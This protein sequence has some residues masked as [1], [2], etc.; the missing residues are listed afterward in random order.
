[1]CSR[2]LAVIV[3]VATPW[4]AAAIPSAAQ[5]S[6]WGANYFPDVTLTT[7]DG[8]SVHFYGDLL[9]G[10][11]VAI[12][13]IYTTCKY[14]CPLETARLAQ[15][16]KLLGDRMGR[17]V[18]FYSITIDPEHD[19]PA[20]LKEY[21]ETFHAGPG[22]L[23]LTGSQEDIELISKKVGLYSSP[24]PSDP[25]GHIPSL[26]V[27]NE[28]TG[29]WMRNSGVDNPKFLAR[30]IG[31]WLNSWQGPKRELKSYA[32]AM[33]L[34]LDPGEYTFN[35]HCA[36]CH[37]FGQGDHIGPDLLGIT[38]TRDRAWLARFILAPDRMFADGDPI[39]RELFEKYKNVRMPNLALSP[40]A[41]AGVVEYLVK[42]DDRTASVTA[43]AARPRPIAAAAI[44][45][46]YLRIQEALSAD[47][48][49]GITDAARSL[50]AEAV[51]L[52]ARGDSIR[53]AAG[54]L[55]HA[56]DLRSARAA[57]GRLSEAIIGD[58]SHLALGD[59]VNVAYCPMLRKY[60]LQ[61]GTAIRNPYY[62]K[63]MLE[64]GRLDTERSHIAR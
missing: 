25:D 34:R 58:Q 47:T 12:N 6:R 7:Q 46:S 41:V 55:Q 50:A 30:T 36:A 45:D 33:P 52:G 56:A 44:I 28:V 20:V 5:N 26:L 38:K 2:A 32:D 49:T 3:A 37:T 1:M 24:D 48:R 21:A 17:D 62:G 39:A 22:W 61:T 59:R 35:Q 40:A 43:P 27:G 31:D 11:I 23:F 57:F 13:L 51:K 15:V 64:C 54:E 14:A 53:S 63:A 42:E 18:F 19:T 8:A 60:W 16:Q 10:K 4:W 9:K 29:Q